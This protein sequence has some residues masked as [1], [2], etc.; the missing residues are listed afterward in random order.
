MSNYAIMRFAKYK[1]G[2]VANIERHQNH[3]D[4]LTHR[5]RPENERMNRTWK[6][7]PEETLTQTARRMVKEQEARTGRRVRKDAVVVVEFVF[8]FSGEMETTI[9]KKE[10]CEANRR[11]LEKQFGEKVIVRSDDN[12]DE[13]VFHQHYFCIM[14]DE[15]DNINATRFFRKKEQVVSLQDSYADAMK[16]F[17]LVRGESKEKTRAKHQSLQEW[18]KNSEAQLVADIQKIEEEQKVIDQVKDIVFGDGSPTPHE[19]EKTVDDDLFAS[20]E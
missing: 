5:V 13:T 9:D 8:T 4:R 7:F 10:W 2:S 17:G 15:K 1:M 20:L 12:Y 18:R 6:Q 11:W 3:R 16:P 14:K 19:R